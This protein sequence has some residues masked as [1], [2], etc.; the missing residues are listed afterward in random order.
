[1]R[2][3]QMEGRQRAPLLWAP[4]NCRRSWSLPSYTPVPAKGK[5]CF[6]WI[7]K[8][9]A[10][11][12]RLESKC[13]HY[14]IY[15]FILVTYPGLHRC[16]YPSIYPSILLALISLSL[17][18]SLYHLYIY[19]KQLNRANIYFIQGM[20]RSTLTCSSSQKPCDVG[21]L[22]MPILRW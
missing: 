1:M 18:L 3:E 12:C 2:K 9:P 19:H 17:S 4:G 15:V 20:L 11:I 22:I 21:T 10:C 7:T 6:W 5:A 13:G 8:S 14:I 16:I